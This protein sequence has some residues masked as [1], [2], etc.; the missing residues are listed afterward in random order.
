MMRFEIKELRKIILKI[1]EAGILDQ[2]ETN[3]LVRFYY[4]SIDYSQ[5]TSGEMEKWIVREPTGSDYYLMSQRWVPFNLLKT[6]ENVSKHFG[7]MSGDSF[8]DV[9]KIWIKAGRDRELS[10][11]EVLETLGMTK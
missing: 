6:V 4:T 3:L 10:A 5:I 1:Q 9:A 2:Q 11:E 7:S 8:V